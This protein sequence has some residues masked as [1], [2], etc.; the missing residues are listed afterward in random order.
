MRKTENFTCDAWKDM[1]GAQKIW[2]G[3]FLL[4][5]S[6]RKLTLL[7]T[8]YTAFFPISSVDMLISEPCVHS[9]AH[10]L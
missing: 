10:G 1:M 6:P 8:S 7:F 4:G 5:R 3:L 9:S 2:I